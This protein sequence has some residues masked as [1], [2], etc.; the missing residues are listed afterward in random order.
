MLRIYTASKL[1]KAAFWREMHAQ[2]PD[3]YFHARW[4]KHNTIGTADSPENARRFWIEDVED[5]ISADYCV[6]YA[7]AEEHLRGALFEAG[8]AVATGVPV[9]V[10]GKHPDYGTWQFHPLVNRLDDW[11]AFNAFVK[12]ELARR[13]Q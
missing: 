12:Q 1:G 7:E 8:V 3:V 2:N 5:V 13:C 9:I 11:V 6:V 4:L 10:V